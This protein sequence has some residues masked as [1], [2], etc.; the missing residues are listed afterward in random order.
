LQLSHELAVR[1]PSGAI[2]VVGT[3]VAVVLLIAFG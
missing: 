3:L 1:A 2:S